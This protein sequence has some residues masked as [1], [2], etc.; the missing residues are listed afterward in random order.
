M[1]HKPSLQRHFGERLYGVITQESKQALPEA[2]VGPQTV[3]LVGPV[4]RTAAANDLLTAF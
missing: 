3:A 4:L 2:G 1:S